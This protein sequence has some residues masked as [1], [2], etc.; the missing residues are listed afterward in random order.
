MSCCCGDAHEGDP[1]WDFIQ[2]LIDANGE[3]IEVS[4]PGGSWKVPRAFIA[5]HGLK[6]EDLGSLADKYGWQRA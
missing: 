5:F 4:T 6:A 3:T 1:R 2:P